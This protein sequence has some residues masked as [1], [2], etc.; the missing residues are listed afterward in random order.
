MEFRDVVRRRRMVRSFTTEPIDRDAR[1][2]ILWALQRGPSAGFS[3]GF[4]FLVL[5][6]DDARRFWELAWPSR[7]RRGPHV[8]TTNAPLV[9]VP[10]ADKGV[11]LD[12]YAEPDKGWSDRDESRWPVPYWIIDTAFASMLALLAVVDEGLGALFFG[13]QREPAVREAFGIPEDVQPIGA[14]AVGHPAEDRPSPSLQRGRR[15]HLV[16]IGRWEPPGP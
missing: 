2:R 6:G 9:I 7:E 8:G 3:Q 14:I 16:R 4:G 15:P 10:C 1:D 11:Y 13:L 5:E 12:R